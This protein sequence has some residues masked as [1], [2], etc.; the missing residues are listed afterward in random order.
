MKLFF[1][2]SRETVPYNREQIETRLAEANACQPRDV[3]I[4]NDR[5]QAD[6]IIDTT[7]ANHL[8]Q[9]P[10]FSVPDDSIGERK[11]LTWDAG[12][13]PTGRR[14]GFY[15]SLPR[16]LFDPKRH[17]SFCY[18][19][20]YNP[21]IREFPQEDATLPWSFSGSLTSGLRA[22]LFQ[23]LAPA[24]G[25]GI[26]RRTQSL[27]MAM[28]DTASESA[29]QAYAD[30]LRRS[31]F[32]LCPRGNGVSSIRL[33][34]V[35][36]AGRV[37]VVISDD[38]VLPACVNW[39]AC[40]LRIAER[41][42]GRITSII[43]GRRDEFPSLAAAARREWERCFSPQSLLSTLASEITALGAP[44]FTTAARSRY[45]SRLA[46][47]FAQSRVKMLA[48]IASRLARKRAGRTSHLPA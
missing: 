5:D 8:L 16:P 27:F 17:R 18:L 15:T 24:S 10:Y 42:L 26:L 36:E 13:F 12:D 34:E 3:E 6:W 46:V 43:A 38:L 35:M 19:I 29:K 32:V 7:P 20:R 41:D 14:N 45:I 31:Q 1:D 9:G 25:E 48:R 23:V 30:D 21:F 33:F 47:A 44:S 11:T 22:R 39:P 40:S 2:L 4:V 28:A 37:P